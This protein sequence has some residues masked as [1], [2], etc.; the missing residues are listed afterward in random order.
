MY[1]LLFNAVQRANK[2][3]ICGQYSKNTNRVDAPDYWI[4]NFFAEF[5]LSTEYTALAYK[6]CKLKNIFIFFHLKIYKN[7]EIAE[8]TVAL[9]RRFFK[10]KMF[11]VLKRKKSGDIIS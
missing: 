11:I 4:N 5:L 7:V 2:S 3:F 9:N 8:K 6:Y 1:S 10:N